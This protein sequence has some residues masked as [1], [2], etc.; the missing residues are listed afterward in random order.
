[1]VDPE[2]APDGGVKTPRVSIFRGATYDFA[3]FSKNCMKLR[4][5]G[6]GKGSTRA[7]F[8]YVDLPLTHAEAHGWI[9]YNVLTTLPLKFK[10]F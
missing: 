7:K 8:C 10:D 1:M 5:F 6:P 2:F 9:Q 3:K 4:E